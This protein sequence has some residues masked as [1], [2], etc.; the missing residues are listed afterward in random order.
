MMVNGG[1]FNVLEEAIK[2]LESKKEDLNKVLNI[3]EC[4]FTRDEIIEV[5]GLSE[6][7]V[8]KNLSRLIKG[9]MLLREDYFVEGKKGR[10]CRYRLSGGDVVDFI[11]HYFN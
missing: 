4:K 11:K 2:H 3:E 6:S 10:H 1:M 7:A 9:G 5:T 8:T